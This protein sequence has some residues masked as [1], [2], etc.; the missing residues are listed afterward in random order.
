MDQRS[1]TAGPGEGMS[2]RSFLGVGAAGLAAAA[3]PAFVTESL[4]ADG[5]RKLP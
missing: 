1:P 2:R 4:C 5:A 3:L